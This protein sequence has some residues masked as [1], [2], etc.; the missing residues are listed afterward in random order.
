MAR[1]TGCASTATRRGRRSTAPPRWGTTAGSSRCATRKT[2][3]PAQRGGHL[4]GARAT[5]ASPPD[6]VDI[7]DSPAAATTYRFADRW[8]VGR[9][10]PAGDAAHAMPPRIGQACAPGRRQPVLE[11]AGRTVGIARG[12]AGHLSGRAASTIVKEVTNRAVKGRQGH[13]RPPPCGPRCAGD[14]LPH[15]EQA[16][17][18]QRLRNNR[19]PPAT[20]PAAGAQRQPRVGWLIPALGDRRRRRPGAVR[21]HRRRPLDRAA[22]RHR[23]GR[24]GVAVRPAHRCPDRRAGSAPG[25]DRIVD[26]DGT[27]LGG[28]RTRRSSVIALRPDGFV[29]AGGTPQRPLPPP[30]AGFTAQA[31]RVKDHA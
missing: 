4:E 11:A 15:R 24:Q 7:L 22:H 19:R 16:A 31:N 12:G 25:A 27:L 13:R 1:P 14:S 30:P 8:R 17:R 5:R 21:R 23:R 18:L 9:V 3:R 28:S 2:R 6:D 29:Y 26:R 10:F 20:G